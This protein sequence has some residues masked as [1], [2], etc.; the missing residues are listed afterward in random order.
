MDNHQPPRV[1]REDFRVR[2]S[3]VDRQNRLKTDALFDYIQQGAAD[4]AD[5][6]GCGFNMATSG[7]MMWVLSRMTLQFRRAP[8]SGERLT[9]QTW[10]SGFDRLFAL[11]EYLLKDADGEI[12]TFGTSFWCLVDFVRMRPL[13]LPEALPVQ[14][15][16][17]SD[18]PQ[19]FQLPA[20]FSIDG[21]DSPMETVVTEHLVDV[22]QHLNNARYA[23]IATD[24]LARQLNHPAALSHLSVNYLLATPP[25][26][27]LVTTGQIDSDGGF[28]L[29]IDGALPDEPPALRFTAQGHLA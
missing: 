25:G 26:T 2:H 8:A 19:H 12:V 22:N 7:N 14:L 10:P 21:L 17:N 20:K 11:R 29:R 13:R 16:D 23:A 5:A 28:R 1:W 6:L 15:P 18:M 24:W 27:R 4:H 9:L 3:E